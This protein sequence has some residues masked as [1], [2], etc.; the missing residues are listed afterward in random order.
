M[1]LAVGYRRRFLSALGSIGL[2]LLTLSA[3]QG[4]QWNATVRVLPD[5]SRVIVEGN[6]TAA[7]V[8]SFLDSY[9][10]MVGLAN[11]VE[12]FTLI[13]EDGN[14][15]PARK[16]APGQFDSPKPAARFRYEV[17]LKPPLMAPDS[18]MV[19]WINN[20]R[21]LLMLADIL[22]LSFRRESNGSNTIIRFTLPPQWRVCSSEIAKGSN[23][24]EV[25]D[26]GQAV[27]A[28]GSQLRTSQINESGMLFN[29]VTD[30]DWA[31]ADREALELAGKVLKAHREV[32]GTM[33]AAQASLTLFPFPQAV[34]PNQWSA[35]TRRSTVTLLMGKLPSKVGA[36][37]QLSTPV[38]HEFFHLW[39]VK[40]IRPVSLEPV[41]YSKEQYTRALWFA[42][43]VT[44][45]YGSF[46]LVRSGLWSKQQF[47]M[48]LSEQINELESRPAN[49]WQS[50]EQSSLDAWL[51]KYPAYRLPVRSISYYNKG[52]VLGFLLDLEMR[53]A[54]NG[55]KSL[56]DLFRWMNETYARRERYFN[57]SEG[58]REAAEALTGSDFRS[59][60]R[61]YVAGVQELPYDEALATVGLKLQH[62]NR[63]S[64]T[65]GFES[66]R[67]FDTAPVVVAVAEGSDAAKAGLTA[68]DSILEINGR[69]ASAEVADMIAGKQP[70][71]NIKLRVQ[72]RSGV[73][74]VKLKLGARREED[75]KIVELENATPAQRARRVA[76]LASEPEPTAAAAVAK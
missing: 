7:T 33:P 72:G 22:P 59:F 48:D 67:N 46:A 66:V 17:S 12:R 38:T 55:S 11:R 29:L 76:W 13:D 14:E 27:F 62:T 71:D 32:F 31:F 69:Q 21:G 1:K 10:S 2:G 49:K 28:V 37:A 24:F 20:D 8:W 52:E 23:E 9:A 40:R 70:G 35:E 3:V 30:G 53:R 16:I 36:L 26:A 57:D 50:A 73:R 42:E 60:F 15:T 4:Q 6:C 74:D 63:I 18:A 34:G 56:R 54:S 45:T 61:A 39:N 75:F 47:Y 44:S 58:V 65:T 68:G 25:R 5:A 64:A 51:E 43:G 19:S 41:D